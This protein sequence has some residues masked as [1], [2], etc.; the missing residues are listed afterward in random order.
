M[1]QTTQEVPSIGL[2]HFSR[3]HKMLHVMIC[4]DVQVTLHLNSMA[5]WYL[6]R[7]KNIDSY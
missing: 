6:S 7:A 5:L 4:N 3:V 1:C 2:T